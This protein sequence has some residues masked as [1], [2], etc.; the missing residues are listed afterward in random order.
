MN[1]TPLRS[2]VLSRDTTFLPCSIKAT[3]MTIM[4][5]Q[6]MV[7][8]GSIH[9]RSKGWKTSLRRGEDSRK[10]IDLT[11]AILARGLK[12][13]IS[14]GDMVRIRNNNRIIKCMSFSSSLKKFR[15]Q[16]T[17]AVNKTYEEF[18]SSNQKTYLILLKPHRFPWKG[19]KYGQDEPK[20]RQPMRASSGRRT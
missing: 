13:L 2:S 20:S 5:R 14:I 1:G 7:W 10:L 3:L 4:M 8:V 12:Y 9:Q 18:S 11:L 16:P 6:R 17:K 15:T 19:K